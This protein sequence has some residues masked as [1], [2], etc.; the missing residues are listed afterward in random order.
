MTSTKHEDLSKAPLLWPAVVALSIFAFTY[1]SNTGAYLIGAIGTLLWLTLAKPKAAPSLPKTLQTLAKAYA[2][3]LV[4][5]MCWILYLDEYPLWDTL[6]AY[7]HY[8]EFLLF[9]PFSIA[10]YH[11]RQHAFTLL[12]VPVAAVVIRIISHTDLSSLDTTLFSN[13]LYGFGKYHTGYGMQGMQ[14]LLTLFCLALFAIKR[15]PS[16]KLRVT[17]AVAAIAT[18]L[19]LTQALMTAGSR[20][21]WAGLAVGVAVLLMLQMPKIIQ[22][23]FDKKT[24]ITVLVITFGI[25]AVIAS[26]SHKLEKRLIRDTN[27][28]FEYSLSVDKLPKDEDVFFARRV[29][30][31]YFGYQL[32]QDRPIFG[33]GPAAVDHILAAHPQFNSHPHLHNTYIQ[34]ASELGAIGFIAVTILFSAPVVLLWR[35]RKSF[36]GE[37][38][39]IMTMLA[40][41]SSS[42][43][44]W[45]L[46]FDH[47]HW[48]DWRFTV[49]WYLSYAALLLRLHTDSSKDSSKNSVL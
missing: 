7:L 32:W 16:I 22:W 42:L 20:G 11:L 46:P 26:N 36:T 45:S 33:H 48:S 30:L 4:L 43:A 21:G 29:H 19:L 3:T 2:A 38:K 40:V 9:V 31:S 14:V 39:V 28:N 6:E 1:R 41:N 13:S 27:V 24:L 37:N 18:A 34:I 17:L 25:L 5:H 23:K 47:L 8:F 35:R 15:P 12:F 44:V 10:L 49:V